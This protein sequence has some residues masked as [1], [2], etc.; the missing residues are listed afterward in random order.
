MLKPWHNRRLDNLFLCPLL[1]FPPVSLGMKE[2]FA[3]LMPGHMVRLML[4]TYL[5][6]FLWATGAWTT[7]VVWN[8]CN[9]GKEKFENCPSPPIPP[10][11]VCVCVML[12]FFTERQ[13]L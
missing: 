3:F 8:I 2:L 6:E 7:V 5:M 12:F 4:A 9:H 1:C 10:V 13:A 11:C